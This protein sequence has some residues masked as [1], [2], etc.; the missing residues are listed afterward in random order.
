LFLIIIGLTIEL[1]SWVLKLEL[2]ER[3]NQRG[4]GIGEGERIKKR[5]KSLFMNV[6]AKTATKMV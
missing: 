2:G 1:F 3:R 4:L 5:R 6:Y